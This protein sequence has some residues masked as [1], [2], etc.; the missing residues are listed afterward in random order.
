MNVVVAKAGKWLR[1]FAD[2]MY[3][4][5]LLAAS[6]VC[7]NGVFVMVML[8]LYSLSVWREWMYETDTEAHYWHFAF[9]IYVVCVVLQFFPRKARVWVRRVLYVIVY[10]V[11]FFEIFL[12][13]RFRII[14]TP[15]SVNLWR[16]TTPEETKEFFTAYCGGEAFWLTLGLLGA[17]GGVHF[18]LRKVCKSLSAVRERRGNTWKIILFMVSANVVL[19]LGMSAHPSLH[20]KNKLWKFYHSAEQAEKIK[21]E[22]FYNPM[23]RLVY[24]FHMLRLADR[25]LD[26][27]KAG[28]RHITV[29]S[30][31]Y[32]CP[33][34]VLVIGESYS[35]H[36]SQLY[37]YKQ[38]TTPNMLRMYQQGDLVVMRD[39]ITPWNLTSRVFKNMLSTHDMNRPGKWT[40]GVLFPAIMRKAGY[41]V[42][43]LTNQFQKSRNQNGVD[44]NGSFFL[45]DEELDTLCFDVRNETGNKLDGEFIQEY[46]RYEPGKYNFVIFH[47]YGQHTQYSCRYDKKQRYFTADSVKRKKLNKAQKGV[48]ADYDNATRYNDSVFNEI[49]MRFKEKDAIIVY[50]SDHG[51]EVYDYIK[52][53][54]RT[55]GDIIDAP[56]AYYEF[57]IPMVVWFSPQFKKRHRDVVAQVRKHQRSPFISYNVSQLVMG[58]AGVSC[59]WYHAERDIFNSAYSPEKR[60]LKG[61]YSYDSILEG[62]RFAPKKKVEKKK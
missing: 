10:A 23:Y 15:T 20:E 58:L 8:L 4:L 37:G 31:S 7:R 6:P 46:D 59:P 32:K 47:L 42:A 60:Y 3:R 56:I 35:K 40:D 12:M 30:C 2:G 5:I 62:S 48:V 21:W 29:D 43:F 1:A 26:N 16:E 28:M 52:M 9:D 36:H 24:S 11:T 45:N 22:T 44:F 19:I 39:A 27:L 33:N 14:Y 13:E 18:L 55:P 57:Q 38:S 25:D 17:A 51:E 50:L 54:G 53:F 49:C 34:I 61:V 41:K